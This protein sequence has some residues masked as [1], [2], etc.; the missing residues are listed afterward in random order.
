M[1][2]LE[3]E[4]ISLGLGLE[5]PSETS[6]KATANIT[7]TGSKIVSCH[8]YI[9]KTTEDEGA[10]VRIK[11]DDKLAAT[12]ICTDLETDINYT[13]KAVVTDKKGLTQ[14]AKKSIFRGNAQVLFLIPQ[15]EIV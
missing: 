14:T 8:F 12:V 3:R 7:E 15:Q 2:N 5:K 6:I 10:Y 4:P 11:K 9:K 13:V 1:E